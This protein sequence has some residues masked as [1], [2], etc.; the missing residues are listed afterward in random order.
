MIS[1][2]S[3]S[4][5]KLRLSLTDESTRARSHMGNNLLTSGKRIELSRSVLL[6][7]DKSVVL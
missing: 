3:T 6:N 5:W 7:L 4:T 1:P 2:G